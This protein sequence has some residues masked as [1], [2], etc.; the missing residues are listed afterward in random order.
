[1]S[2]TKELFI[3]TV[4]MI[5]NHLDRVPR[6]IELLFF[7]LFK[8]ISGKLDVLRALP[9]DIYKDNVLNY[10]KIS[11][12]YEKNSIVEELKNHYFSNLLMENLL[13]EEYLLKF[14]TE[15]KNVLTNLKSYT[16]KFNEK[17]YCCLYLSVPVFKYLDLD[18]GNLDTIFS[19]ISLLAKNCHIANSKISDFGLSLEINYMFQEIVY[20]YDEFINSDM[21]N[22]TIKYKFINNYN[23]ERM[24]KNIEIPLSYLHKAYTY[25]IKDDIDELINK[26]IMRQTIFSH[27]F[28]SI[29]LLTIILQIIFIINN[30]FYIK[31]LSFFSEIFS[32]INNFKS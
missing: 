24:I 2:N 9:I 7:T 13:I 31:A 26:V 6:F 17:G 23:I 21:D 8:I 30:N 29:S 11:L 32:N 16:P 18:D 12:P 25:F 22:E 3:Y 14:A 15:K 28:Y 5:I 10:Y 19:V 27:L 20:I 4:V 1:M